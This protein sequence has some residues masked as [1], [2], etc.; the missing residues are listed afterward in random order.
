MQRLRRFWVEFAL[1]SPPVD[2]PPGVMAGCGVTAFDTA[3]ALNIIQTNVFRGGELPPLQSLVADVDVS[4]LDSRH[5]IP[6]IGNVLKRGVWFP[7]GY[8]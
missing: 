7:Q 3:D 5:V 2:S 4:S 8:Q 6:N 1:P